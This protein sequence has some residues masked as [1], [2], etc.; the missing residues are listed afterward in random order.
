[1]LGM[2]GSAIALL[3]VLVLTAPFDPREI[4]A[5]RVAADGAGADSKTDG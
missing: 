2:A 5:I 4:V 1:M 3:P